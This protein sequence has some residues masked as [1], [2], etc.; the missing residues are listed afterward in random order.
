[1]PEEVADTRPVSR[2][3]GPA[4]AGHR[5]AQPYSLCG[6]PAVLHFPLL[7]LGFRRRLHPE[8]CLW[9]PLG[10]PRSA[11]WPPAWSTSRPL[12]GPPGRQASIPSWLSFWRLPSC[13]VFSI[14]PKNECP[15]REL[16][17]QGPGNCPLILLV[18]P[19]LKMRSPEQC[20]GRPCQ[21][22]TAL[23]CRRCWR[24]HHFRVQR[25]ALDL[26]VKQGANTSQHL[27]PRTGGE[28]EEAVVWG[29]V[30]PSVLCLSSEPSSLLSCDMHC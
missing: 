20:P 2:D 6:A 7:S 27:G 30:L 13:C 23:H 8:C 4:A 24:P 10:G 28:S 19:G 18:P 1:M 9:S 15:G 12:L 14:S 25:T 26:G 21:P 5:G 16:C 3:R 22:V 11:R 17:H 29:S